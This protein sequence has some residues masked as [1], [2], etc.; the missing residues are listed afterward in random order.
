MLIL[1]ATARNGRRATNV[2][3]ALQAYRIHEAH[4]EIAISDHRARVNCLGVVYRHVQASSD[5][6]GGRHGAKA[7]QKVCGSIATGAAA[8]GIF[9][10]VGAEV[11]IGS[12]LINYFTQVNIGN[13][14]EV[15]AAGYVS[16][17]WAGHGGPLHRFGILQ[18]VQTNVVLGIG[19]A[20]GVRA[21]VGSS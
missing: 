5:A 7:V 17:Y 20:G 16:Y 2:R 15:V 10:Y 4:R 11:S 19:R 18:K 14:S 3:D 12:F 21:V 1:N 13:V 6:R 9:V 8:I